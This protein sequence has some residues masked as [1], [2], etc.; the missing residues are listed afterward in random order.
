[1]K[2]KKA[3]VY[4]LLMYVVNSN[5]KIK[6]FDSVEKMA[7]FVEAFQKKHPDHLASESGDWIDYCITKVSGDVH[8]FTDGIE[9]Q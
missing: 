8:F 3:E 2:K 5:P 6:R 9:V 7:K 1:M 4:H